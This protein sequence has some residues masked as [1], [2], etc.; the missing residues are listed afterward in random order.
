MQGK[1]RGLYQGLRHGHDIACFG[2]RRFVPFESS[3]SDKTKRSISTLQRCGGV[4]QGRQS[5]VLSLR[6]EARERFLAMN[7]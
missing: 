3:D 5:L 7:Y 4:C 2:C 6:E 1:A